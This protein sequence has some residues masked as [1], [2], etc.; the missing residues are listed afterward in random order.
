MSTSGYTIQFSEDEVEEVARALKEE[1]SGQ[2]QGDHAD[3]LVIGT[4]ELV[5][6]KTRDE[7]LSEPLVED[8]GGVINHRI[9][10]SGVAPQLVEEGT[11]DIQEHVLKDEYGED[12]MWDVGDEIVRLL[13]GPESDEIVLEVA[14]IVLDHLPGVR[15]MGLVRRIV[16]KV[17]NK[18]LGRRADLVV[19]DVGDVIISTLIEKGHS[20]ELVEETLNIASR[21]I[22]EEDES[23]SL[24][25]SLVD[26][27]VE[28]MIEEGESD[29]LVD[30]TLD[31][32]G[33]RLVDADLS[34]DVVDDTL[35]LALRRLVMQQLVEDIVRE[36][37]EQYPAD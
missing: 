28:E 22:V 32:T 20:D 7:D 2:L 17:A 19:E 16:K 35:E 34:E 31:V 24:A 15:R 9:R 29:A 26:T 18:L 1:I 6:R 10:E 8:V 23:T 27:A 25:T 37:Q 36:M 12:I 4:T 13:Q 3:E 5:S 33:D 30:D 21:K 11:V 14:D